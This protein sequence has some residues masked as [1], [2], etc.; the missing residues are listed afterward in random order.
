MDR[1]SHLI[2]MIVVD[3]YDYDKYH[4]FICGRE[5]EKKAWHHF[6]AE[7]FHDHPC[8]VRFGDRLLFH[9]DKFKLELD[10]GP[11]LKYNVPIDEFPE[12][13]MNRISEETPYRE[14]SN[15]KIHFWG[16]S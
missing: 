6:M 7:D 16:L 10:R 1:K 2:S 11:F 12:E 15:H 8:L 3:L 14:F 5:P 4:V 9:K 13:L